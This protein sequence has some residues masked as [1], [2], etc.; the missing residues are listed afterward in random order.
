MSSNNKWPDFRLAS[1]L[2]SLVGSHPDGADPS[3]ST[4]ETSLP[5]HN[6]DQQP[7]QELSSDERNEKMNGSHSVAQAEMD[8]G[9]HPIDAVEA[10]DNFEHDPQADGELNDQDDDFGALEMFD[11]NTAPEP[12]SSQMNPSPFDH[13]SKAPEAIMEAAPPSSEI[14]RSKRDKKDRKKKVASE[15]ADDA[16]SPIADDT[17]RRKKKSKRKSSLFA[18]H[19]D[20]LSIDEQNHTDD[21]VSNAYLSE[22]VAESTALTKRKRTSSDAAEETRRK[23]RKSHDHVTEPSQEVVPGTQDDEPANDGQ[24][25]LPQGLDDGVAVIADLGAM[26]V[27]FPP[28]AQIPENPFEDGQLDTNPHINGTEDV[29]D[30][31]GRREMESIAKEALEEAIN[32]QGQ[33]E[34]D[35]YDV[36]GSPIQTPQAPSSNSK[37]TRSARTKKAKP[38]YYEEPPTTANDVSFADLSK[39]T[40]KPRRAKKASSRRKSLPVR[41]SQAGEDGEDGTVQRRAKMA[42]YV[43]GRFSDAELSRIAVAVE[44]FCTEH[45]LTRF[46]V[47]ELI[48]APGGT[49][50]GDE[51][52][53]LWGRVFETCPDRHRQKI[54]NITRKKFHNF[55]ARGTW[56]PEQDAELR[57]LIEANGTKWSKI[58]AIINRHPEDLRDRYRNYIVCGAAQ[59][60]DSWDETEERNLTQY[61]MEAMGAI[62]ELRAID[63][64]RDLLQKPYEE[65]IDWQN[66]SERMERTR[67][68]LQ[69]ITK[70]KALNI[71]THGK[72]KL[73]S[74]QPDAQI[75]F[76]LEKARR[77]IADMPDEERYRLV[78]AID[79][80]SVSDDAK[81]PWQR[82]VDKQYRNSWHRTTQV[83]LWHRLKHTVPGWTELTVRD[84]TQ[85][86]LDQ[87]NQVGELPNVSDDM[88]DDA[89]EMKFFSTIPASAIANGS[90]QGAHISDEYVANSDGEAEAEAEAE[91]EAQHGVLDENIQPDL[92]IDPLLPLEEAIQPNLPVEPIEDA[93]PV[94]P[95]DVAELVEAVDPAAAAEAEEAE[96]VVPEFVEPAPPRATRSAKKGSGKGRAP[97]RSAPARTPKTPKRPARRPAAPSQDPIEDEAPLT[98]PPAEDNNDSD[99][100]ESRLRKRKTPGKFRSANT[101]EAVEA[102]SDYSDSAMDDMEDLPARVPV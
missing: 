34:P 7:R 77:Q 86:L 93:V 85:Y 15:G 17:P 63:P 24:N 56:T 8:A 67:S 46:Q 68:R 32:G 101:A 43:Q 97:R 99:I 23:K 79:V 58:A 87:Y 14:R 52:A 96:P 1:T 42:S 39:S 57:D 47:N 60:K 84:C 80:S 65:L 12:Y 48:H 54:I 6:H 91:T 11:S 22:V 36:P 4:N 71:K 3:A 81:I 26:D 21:T 61:V 64:S 16:Q 10:F 29:E 50:A 89:Q 88:F 19:L 53:A 55:V 18:E 74:Q 94:A 51:H 75:S 33:D 70:W 100:D 69:C 83:L 49:T 9:V 27:D 95:M 40:P 45:D 76:R 28:S 82:L 13:V 92:P 2:W 90:S 38:T 66:I 31:E 37:R 30:G 44:S 5:P 73:A 98:Q 62:D 35:I 102:K 41:L 59:R 72:D 78:L 20:N 25:G